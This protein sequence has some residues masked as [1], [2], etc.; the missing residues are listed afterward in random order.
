MCHRQL[1]GPNTREIVGGLYVQDTLGTKKRCLSAAK[2]FLAKSQSVVVDATNRDA[3]TRADWLALAKSFVRQAASPLHL[4]SQAN[5]RVSTGQNARA[6]AVVFETSKDVCFHLNEFR[7]ADPHTQDRRK[8]PNMVIHSFF[9]NGS[10][11][12]VRIASITQRLSSRFAV[13]VLC[14]RCTHI[15][16]SPHRTWL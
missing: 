11:P 8:V 10:P 7:F 14:G 5:A 1:T 3:K 2:A 9:K 6:R 16:T 4:P 12:T 15:A 13:A